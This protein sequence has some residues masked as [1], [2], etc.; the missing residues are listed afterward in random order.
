MKMIS[1]IEDM[2][3]QSAVMETPLATTP[4][5]CF[6]G[7]AQ[8]YMSSLSV[9]TNAIRKFMAPKVGGEDMFGHMLVRIVPK[10]SIEGNTLG[11]VNTRPAVFEDETY[12]PNI[13]LG[14]EIGKK[15]DVR[16]LNATMRHELGHTIE[17]TGPAPYN[18]I[19]GRMRSRGLGATLLAAGVVW[20]TEAFNNIRDQ[21]LVEFDTNSVAFGSLAIA[22]LSCL[23]SPKAILRQY[24]PRELKADLFS[25][26]NRNF[27]PISIS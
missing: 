1:K 12:F 5:I 22:G 8:Q 3:E 10:K 2:R 13:T 16:K 7:E 21:S 15:Q 27:L 14:V 20:G 17:P 23:A 25:L 9:D 18:T 24:G 26:Q 4:M 11:Y 19:M 6:E